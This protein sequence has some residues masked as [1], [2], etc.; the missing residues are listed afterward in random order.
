[1]P[2]SFPLA[3]L[4]FRAI[5]G[6]R[7]T[8]GEGDQNIGVL[9][10][11]IQTAYN[12]SIKTTDVTP[13]TDVTLPLVASDETV[14]FR[15]G[16]G[17]KAPLS[18]LKTFVEAASAPAA[19]TA[20]QWTATAGVGS[21]ELNITALPDNGGSALTA[22]EYRLNGGSAVALSGTGTGIRT[23]S[24]L[25][26]GVS[27]DVQIRAVNAVGAGGWSDTKTR[28]PTSAGGT[29]AIVQQPVKAVQVF[30][31]VYER[32]LSP[33]GAGNGLLVAVLSPTSQ[34]APTVTD[35]NGVSFGSPVHTYV[36]GG[37][38]NVTMRF[39]AR[40]NITGTPPTFVRATF[41]SDGGGF[42]AAVEVSGGGSSIVADAVGGAAE[43]SDTNWDFPF[44]STVANTVFLGIGAYTNSNL[45]TATAPLTVEGNAAD[46]DFYARGLFPTA[47]SNTGVVTTTDA[48]TGDKAWCVFRPGP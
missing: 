18:A 40:A 8:S 38:T 17:Y 37:L 10:A 31:T 4:I 42:I 39:Y 32:S 9:E 33:V 29:L 19:F 46:F 14:I 23:I 2:L 35:S 5:K 36:G 47:G 25:T 21:I 3:G 43:T 26:G 44:T 12:E 11:A 15:G 13:L 6:S 22:L 48:R 28:T 27:Y 41:G 45:A 30:G 1:M 7:L 20:G 24:G 34:G 16:V